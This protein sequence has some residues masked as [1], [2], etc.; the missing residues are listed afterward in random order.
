MPPEGGRKYP[1]WDHGASLLLKDYFNLRKISL[2]VLLALKKPITYADWQPISSPDAGHW[3]ILRWRRWQL[4]GAEGWPAWERSG[5]LSAVPVTAPLAGGQRALPGLLPHHGEEEEGRR[6][7]DWA[8]TSD[9]APGSK[10]G[11]LR[12]AV[13]RGEAAAPDPRRGR[14]GSAAWEKRC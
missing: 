13:G 10:S 12:S 7:G 11:R 5:P 3:L 1:A 9:P 8:A 2:L 6:A 4:R 14:E